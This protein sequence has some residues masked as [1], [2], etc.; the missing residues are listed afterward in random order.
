MSRTFR[1]VPNQVIRDLL[2]PERANELAEQ[3]LVDHHRGD[4][5]WA[6]PRQMDLLPSDHDTQYKVKGCV[7][8]RP[9]IAGFRVVGLNR[10]AEG[11]R[12]MAQRPTKNVLLY[13]T[14]TAELFGVVD[15]RHGYGMR[16]GACSAV[17]LKHLAAAG[18]DECAMVGTGHMAYG[19]LVTLA[20]AI[21]LRR[22]RVWSRSRDRREAFA[23]QMADELGIEVVAAETAQECVRDAPLVI[24]AT[25]APSP[26]LT[27]DDFAPGVTIYAMGGNQE[28]ET[29]ALRQMTLVVDDREQVLKTKKYVVSTLVPDHGYTDDWVTADLPEV[30]AGAHPGRTSEDEQIVVISQGLVTQDVAQAYWVY[31]EVDRRELGVSLEHSLEGDADRSLY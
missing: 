5:E 15:E 1:Y 2:T 8:R 9:G 27:Q 4:I 23:R 14:A 11:Q 6:S 22:I 30:V 3:T 28:I 20:A 19:S 31:E 7:L 21:K 25:T 29:Q 17:A 16:T 26:F 12:V 10:T 24:T 13:D 18:A